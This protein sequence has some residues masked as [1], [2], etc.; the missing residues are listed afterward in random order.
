MKK[1]IYLLTAITV[2]SAC[3]KEVLTLQDNNGIITESPNGT[4]TYTLTARIEDMTKASIAT[5]GTFS[6]TGVG[7][8]EIA[9][10]DNT[11][12]EYV[13]FTLSEI[14]DPSKKEAK[15]S[16][17]AAK[18]G[19]SFDGQKAYY[20]A[21]VVS[22]GE[23]LFPTSFASL[24]DA[25][26]SFPMQGTVSGNEI[27]F[28]H[29]GCLI[30]MTLN[31][32]PSFTRALILNYGSKEDI[33]VTATPTEGVINAVV[34]V[35]AGTY[36]LT[37]K[38][39]DDNNN[40]FYTKARESKTYTARN[41][42]TI[43][44]IELGPIVYVQKQ[45]GKNYTPTKIHTWKLAG[46][47]ITTWD[48]RPLLKE[49]ANGTLYYLYDNQY[50]NLPVG[51]DITDNSGNKQETKRVYLDRDITLTAGNTTDKLIGTY[52]IYAST[53]T[54]F[55]TGDVKVF[56]RL[57]VGSTEYMVS[58]S[59]P[60]S[61]MTYSSTLSMWFWDYNMSYSAWNNVGLTFYDVNRGYST[62]QFYTGSDKAVDQDIVVTFNDFW[63][64][65]TEGSLSHID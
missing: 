6:W 38:L 56:A 43:K 63:S 28:N 64:E 49:L 48:T 52:R 24:E 21:S 62:K 8:D 36:V 46:G 23:F 2:L 65:D 45:D 13:T 44:P 33:T 29:L 30:N 34:P 3:A 35:P 5:N 42:Y 12:K 19:A 40:I 31:N 20:P 39:K 1:I 7:N 32:V 58:A 50:R 17:D 26:K 14:T 22:T 60:G 27:N 37:A 55:L 51:I 4:A 11:N 59:S 16:T 54:T 57:W 18:V 9:I 47:D 53:N 41:Y 25:A 15:F 10:W 61:L